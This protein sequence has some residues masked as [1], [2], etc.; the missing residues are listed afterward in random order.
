MGYVIL[1]LKDDGWI[2]ST[3]DPFTLNTPL[4]LRT[5]AAATAFFFFP[6]VWT[7]WPF[8]YDILVW[9]FIL[10]LFIN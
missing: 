7:S 10:E 5:V 2:K 8:T 6:K 1:T 4:P 3:G 9:L